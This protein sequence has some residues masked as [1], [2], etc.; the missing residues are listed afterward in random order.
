MQITSTASLGEDDLGT[1]NLKNSIFF[2]I[3]DI[4]GLPYRTAKRRRKKEGGRKSRQA[5]GRGG[6]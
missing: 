4:I 3:I 5:G 2:P 1:L 6:G